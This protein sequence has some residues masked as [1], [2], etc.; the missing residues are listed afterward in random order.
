M[1]NP[2]F[3]KSGIQRIQH[4]LKILRRK[5]HKKVSKA[6]KKKIKVDKPS[7]PKK[8]VSKV[9][10]KPKKPSKPSKP[11]KSVVKKPP[12][13]KPKPKKLAPK[14]KKPAPKTKPAPKPEK[15]E[16]VP[17][18]KT[19]ESRVEKIVGKIKNLEIQGSN[20]IAE[21]GVRCLE[22]MAKESSATKKND[23]ISELRKTAEIV[24]GAR[25]TEPCLQNSVK[26]ILDKLEKYELRK[27]ENVRKYALSAC[28]TQL[29][30][31]KTVVERIAE[32]GVGQIQDDDVVLTHCH[33]EHV[34]AI[35]KEARDKRKKFSVIV[36]ETRPLRQGLITAKELLE[37][38]IDV[39]FVVDSSVASLMKKVTKVLIGCDA[40]LA[41]GSI[42]SK[43]GTYTI[44]LIAD[45]FQ[46][47]VFVAG[48]TLK[49]DPRTV[50]GMPEP[51]EQRKPE[52]I[53]DP[54]ELRG[55]KILNPAFDITP[56]ELITALI[57]EK[58]IMRPE[59]IRGAA[60]GL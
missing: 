17:P 23:F 27:M 46:T 29:D 21:A 20:D 38:N 28:R 6:P 1:I 7:K 2:R 49:F 40:I 42:V 15:P 8:I 34:V 30:L 25:P 13:P 50:Q 26:I 47:P 32:I 16:P 19:P 14:P 59:L 35:L 11:K 44:A 48:E 37:A 36:T 33:S 45:K 9:P 3:Y 43:I 55:A 52:E 51:I 57:T 22:I 18:E 4:M 10:K 53:I 58:G 24:K 5:K 31:L 60:D 54:A 12:K 56:A 41:D 39:I